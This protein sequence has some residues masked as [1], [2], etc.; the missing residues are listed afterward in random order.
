MAL[1]LTM[2]SLSV[3]DPDDISTTSSPT[4]HSSLSDHDQFNAR[5]A[6]VIFQSSDGV[7]FHLHRTNLG[8]ITGAFPGAEL[9]TRDEVVHLAEPARVLEIL[10]QYVYPKR[11]PD[12]EN[13]DFQLLAELAEAVEKYEVFPAMNTC[14][15]RLRHYTPQHPL[16]TL[17]HG[18]KHDY[19][20]LIDTAAPHLIMSPL[21]AICEKLPLVCI[22][23]WLRFYSYTRE[24]IFGAARSFIDRKGRYSSCHAGDD[25]I[26][27]QCRSCVLAWIADL[28]KIES[29][30]ALQAALM[31]YQDYPRFEY[32]SKCSYACMHMPGVAKMCEEALTAIRSFSSFLTGERLA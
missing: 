25:E 10:F 14:V 13:L 26:C 9:D 12:L 21:V 19:P 8:V 31:K 4:A 30:E 20:K 22:V 32:C 16:E 7:R 2:G 11:H 3:A 15:T 6:D 18:I 17:V 28:E 29:R 27:N 24:A 1:L 5:D 23:P